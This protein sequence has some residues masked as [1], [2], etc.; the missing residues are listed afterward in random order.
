VQVITDVDT[1]AIPEVFR[2]CRTCTY[3]NGDKERT[4]LLACFHDTG[5]FQTLDPLFVIL[6][7][8]FGNASIL[9]GAMDNII[10]YPKMF[11]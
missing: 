3:E 7:K 10:N 6:Q 8:T 2:F 9:K 11:K 1:K 4:Q 5:F